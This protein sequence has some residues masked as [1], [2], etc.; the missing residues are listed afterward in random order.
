[1]EDY[2]EEALDKKVEYF[3]KS[4]HYKGFK[5][6]QTFLLK[7]S[8]FSQKMC[9]KKYRKTPPSPQKIISPL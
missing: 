4:K 7:M 8:S 5:I 9:Y 2:V 1:M 6:A 3:V